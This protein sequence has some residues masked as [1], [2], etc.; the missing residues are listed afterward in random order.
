MPEKGVATESGASLEIHSHV[1]KLLK[2]VVHAVMDNSITHPT[3]NDFYL[4]SHSGIQG[5]SRPAHYH[6]LLDQ[7]KFTPDELQ[8]FTYH[9]TFTFCRCTRSV[10]MCPPGQSTASLSFLPSHSLTARAC[11]PADASGKHVYSPM[12]AFWRTAYYASLA[13]T[14]GRA[15]LSHYQPTSDS[16]SVASFSRGPRVGLHAEFANIHRDLSTRMYY[17]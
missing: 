16:E 12:H 2:Y 11:Q 7:N 9:L 13:A 6:V 8:L 17:V 5:T 1:F 14:R 4:L 15:M 3:E 10:S